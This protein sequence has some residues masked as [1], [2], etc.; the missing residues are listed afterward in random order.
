MIEE[1]KSASVRR[2]IRRHRD[3]VAIWF[4]ASFFCLGSIGDAL[5]IAGYGACGQPV[6]EGAEPSVTD[7]LIILLFAVGLPSN[8]ES[9]ACICDVNYAGGFTNVS[10][11]DALIVLKKAVGQKVQLTCCPP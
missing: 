6:T 7:A 4:I 5:A 9:R 1:R 11:V 8:C 10:A 3:F 2:R